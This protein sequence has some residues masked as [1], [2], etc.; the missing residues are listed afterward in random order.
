MHN[1]N[2]ESAFVQRVQIAPLGFEVDRITMPLER[3]KADKLWLLIHNNASEDKS[4]RYA[5]RIGERCAELGVELAT[6]RADRMDLF[7][8]SKAVR[9]VIIRECGNSIHINVAA[10]SKIQA[11]ACMMACMSFQDSININP[12]YAVP[13]KYTAQEASK[14]GDQQISHGLREIISLP[15]YKMHKPSEK[16]LKALDMISKSGGRVAKKRLASMVQ[17]EGL[18]TV[19]AEESNQSQAVYA[20]LQNNITKPLEREWGMITTEKI[21][22][23]HWISL[24]QEGKDTVR[25]LSGDQRSAGEHH[26]PSA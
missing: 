5:K 22:R 3:G 18:I 23:S 17:N 16:L 19:R 2:T 4:I 1:I 9:E 25:F 12:F 13:E 15:V 7:D 11:I 20:S 26:H 21:G 14:P 8:I 6:V 10:G 24:T